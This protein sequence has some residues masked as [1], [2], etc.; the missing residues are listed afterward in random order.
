[1]SKKYQIA[2]SFAGEDRPYVESVAHAL[3]SAGIT[4]FY[5]DFEKVTLW[6][7]NLYDYLSDI[8]R[9]QASLCVLFLSEHYARKRWTSLERQA[10]QARAFSESTDYILPVRFD[11]TEIPGIH[12]TVGY[13]SLRHLSPQELAR[14]LALKLKE[15]G[16]FA[17]GTSPQD[18]IEL[19][20]RLMAA[21]VDPEMHS[22][23]PLR[24]LACPKCGFTDL[25]R[26]IYRDRHHGMDSAEV[27]CGNCDWGVSDFIAGEKSF[28]Y[29]A[30]RYPAI[31]ESW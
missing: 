22:E 15:I 31:K 16:A 14:M 7:K 18:V 9:N 11:D 23:N 27:K 28:E 13:I 25:T 1:M 4:V 21:C 12:S 2:L 24:F 19:N 8:Y 30:K 5:D 26:Q 20:R 29:Y 17:G 3:V 6:G 10:A